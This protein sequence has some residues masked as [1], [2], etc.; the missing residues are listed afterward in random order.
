MSGWAEEIDL[1]YGSWRLQ[2]RMDEVLYHAKTEHQEILLFS[3][4]RYIIGLRY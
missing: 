2:M 4:L 3:N 1:V